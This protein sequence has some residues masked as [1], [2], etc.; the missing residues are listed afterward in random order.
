[1]M[2]V[3]KLRRAPHHGSRRVTSLVSS[4]ALGALVGLGACKPDPED[5]VAPDV[6]QPE[7]APELSDK[8]RKA[9][10]AAQKRAMLEALPPLPGIEDPKPIQFPEP[11]ISSLDNGLQLVVLEDHET[12]RATVQLI[13]RAGNIYAPA[14]N[15]ELASLCAAALTE[16]TTKTK[17]AKLDETIDD[18]G[19][20]LGAGADDEV[21]AISASMLS[22][23]LNVALKIIA[24]EAQFP[25]F[26]DESLTKVKDQMILGLRQEKANT[27]AL[28]L[29]M[30]QRVLYGDSSPYGRPFATEDAITAITAEQLRAFHAKH[31]VPNNATLLV[32]GDVSADAVAK[33]AKKA[34]G[35]WKRGDDVPVPRSQSAP[36]LDEP[37]VHIIDRS[38][39]VQA[40]IAVVMRAPKIGDAGWLETQLLNEVLSGGTLTTRLNLVLREQLGLTY[41]AYSAHFHGYDGGALL[42]GGGTKNSSAAEFAEALIDLMYEFG[43]AP[44]AAKELERIK[45]LVS[46]SFALESEGAGFTAA[47]TQERLLYDLP[48][49]F[50]ST[51]RVEIDKLTPEQLLAVGK[52]VMDRGHLQL[53]AIGKAK[54]LERELEAFGEVRIYSTDL[55][56]IDE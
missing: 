5:T 29:R 22:G 34:F 38:G 45:S 55:E 27:Q 2:A 17:K 11:V 7:P 35:K 46:G 48:E 3:L 54:A 40:T 6:T 4:L 51:Y 20:S 42:G 39:S 44:V 50:W 56:R 9:Q 43:A 19:G 18:T 21:A 53:I 1:M 14:S 49:E 13:V 28:A 47:K 12:P 32:V 41:G 31:Y 23:D 15:T 10:E 8:E 16:G 26:E 52:T 37:M 33:Q 25:A 30:A 24:E 36:A